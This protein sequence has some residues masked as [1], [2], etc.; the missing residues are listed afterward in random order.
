MS[1][2]DYER[3]IDSAEDDIRELKSKIQAYQNNL[4]EEERKEAAVEKRIKEL[5]SALSAQNRVVSGFQGQVEGEDNKISRANG[6]ISKQEELVTNKVQSAFEAVRTEYLKDRGSMQGVDLGGLDAADAAESKILQEWNQNQKTIRSLEEQIQNNLEY[7]KER[8]QQISQ[9]SEYL[10]EGTSGSGIIQIQKELRAELVRRTS[11][12]PETKEAYL[13]GFSRIAGDVRTELFELGA[14]LTPGSKYTFIKELKDVDATAAKTAIKARFQKAGIDL[15]F[16]PTYTSLGVIIDENLLDTEIALI[17]KKVDPRVARQY[18]LMAMNLDWSNVNA[19]RKGVV[20]YMDGKFY[21]NARE[22]V[23]IVE[24][25][26]KLEHVHALYL[27]ENNLVDQDG[28]LIPDNMLEMRVP[29][30][31][32]RAAI[33]FLRYAQARVTVQEYLNFRI[34]LEKRDAEVEEIAQERRSIGDQERE[35]AY[36]LDHIINDT[37]ARE[38]TVSLGERKIGK[39]KG[40]VN[41]VEVEQERE[42]L[43]QYLA[44][45]KSLYAKAKEENVRL[46]SQLEIE[47]SKQG[48]TDYQDAKKILFGFVSGLIEKYDDLAPKEL[49]QLPDGLR[50]IVAEADTY[51]DA[52]QADIDGQQAAIAG[53]ASTR[54][55]YQSQLTDAEKAADKL[56][57]QISAIE[58]SDLSP[59]QRK[60]KSIEQNISSAES[61]IREL[62][63]DISGYQSSIRQIELDESRKSYTS[64]TTNFGGGSGGGGT[65]LGR[66]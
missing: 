63:S 12:S 3:K 19:A 45:Q 38:V 64:T 34:E 18:S 43:T 10:G 51:V 61:D 13:K 15:A 62:K 58:Q 57:S 16:V 66:R 60:I 25:G 59:I 37:V 65:Q 50:T 33:K 7:Q 44:S 5:Q 6:I 26:N 31:A 39:L 36:D 28:V 29:S 17:A 8:M 9:T 11:V 53:F 30:S 49:R 14:E 46:T 35:I 24:Q 1:K 2:Y 32:E 54:K 23:R 48:A 4:E 56:E 41:L 47:T 27:L 42:R 55:G 40:T 20:D 52:R 22:A 21:N